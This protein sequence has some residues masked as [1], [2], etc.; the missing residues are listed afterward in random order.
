MQNKKNTVRYTATLPEDYVYELKELAKE[1]KIPS[2]NYA[3][4]EALGVYL[5][6]TRKE[7]FEEQMKEA[8]K[9]KAFLKRTKDCSDDFIY[10]DSEVSGDW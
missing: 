8:A 3:I 4:K 1:E 7:Q 10:V 6:Q 5:K 2:V 9:D